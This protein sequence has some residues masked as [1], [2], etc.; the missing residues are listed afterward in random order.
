MGHRSEVN[1]KARAYPAQPH[2]LDIW[3]TKSGVSARTHAQEAMGLWLDKSSS[4]P[5]GENAD[6]VHTLRQSPPRYLARFTA[7]TQRLFH[8]QKGSVQ[9]QEA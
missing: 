1:S 5:I 3:L 8:L 9:L 2:I 4:A 6:R 7:D